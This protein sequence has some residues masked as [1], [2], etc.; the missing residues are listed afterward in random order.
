M[1]NWFKIFIKQR[2]ALASICAVILF[3]ACSKNGNPNGLPDADPSQYERP[4]QEGVIK[5]LA[6]GNSFSE[7][8]IETHLYQLAK[9]KGIKVI[10]GNLYIGGASLSD[11]KQNLERNAL[12]YDYRKIEGDTVK[13]SFPK[14]SLALAIEDENWDY[15]SFQQV[16]QNS[17]QFET[18]QSTLPAVYNYVKSKAKNPAAKY[19]YHQTWAYAQNSTHDGFV[20]YNKDQMTMYNAIVDVSKKVKDI[21]PIDIIVPAGTAIQNGRTSVVEDNFTRDGYHLAIP[22]GRY[23]A[24]CTWFETLFGQSVVGAAYRPA[25]LSPFE[26]SIAQNAAHL[27]VLKPFEVTEMTAFQG[28]NGGPLESPVLVDF[29]NAA[30]SES[31][32]QISAFIAG[33]KINL[34]DSLNSYV[35]LSLTIVNRFNGINTN[36]ATATTTPLNMPDNVSSRNFFGSSKLPFGGIPAGNAVFTIAGLDKDL[37]Y[38]FSFFGSRAATN[39]RET[40]YTVVGTNQGEGSINTGSNATVIAIVNNIKPDADGKVTITVSAGPNNVTAE[41]FYYLNA[42]KITSNN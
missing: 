26:V 40:K 2:F 32:N 7:D 33:S 9:E 15:I 8:A 19:I 37:T 4:S 3:S 23:T 18:V 29:G 35:G 25:G 12:V 30:R 1:K 24:A 5:I 20:N 6:I 22:I 21:V 39:N 17:G 27:A 10:I 14:T 28:G 31:W 11:H 36:G 41:G 38:N 34:K 42:A 16:S 13:K